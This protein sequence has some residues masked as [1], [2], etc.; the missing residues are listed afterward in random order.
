MAGTIRTDAR[1]ARPAKPGAPNI[2]MLTIRLFVLACSLLLAVPAFAAPIYRMT[3][4]RTGYGAQYNVTQS[5]PFQHADSYPVPDGSNAI[6]SGYAF[7]FPGHVG[8]D[9]RLE[10]LWA[11]GQVNSSVYQALSYASTDDFLISGSGQWVEGQL[12]FR[13]RASLSRSGSG[14]STRL[15]VDARARNGSLAAVGD[16]IWNHLGTNGTG[17]LAGLTNPDLDFAFVLSGLFPVGTPFNVAISVFGLENCSAAVPAAWARADA[18]TNPIY[19]LSLEEVGGQVLT[20]PAG[21]TLNSASWGVVDNHF[22]T[23][24][25]V[26]GPEPGS[27][28]PQMLAYPNPFSAATII[29]FE[30]PQAAHLRLQIFEIGGRLVRTL[31]DQW[32]VA[33]RQEFA[34]D[35]RADD[36]T[37]LGTGIYFAR[38]QGDGR[39]ESQRIVRMR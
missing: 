39:V 26:V 1:L 33:G 21:Y 5:T 15:N 38:V 25:G 34:W 6:F 27:D 8:V 3:W 28:S 2:I 12:H 11:S 23:G 36:G 10:H 16:L 4:E 14:Q 18:G 32:S 20:L 24:V 22:Q 30:L 35:G 19:G 13:A 7:A 17:L 37:A 9:N 29:S 31:V